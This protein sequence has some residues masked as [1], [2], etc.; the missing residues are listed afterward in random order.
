MDQQG[1]EKI[2]YL[3]TDKPRL[4]RYDKE[5]AKEI[6]IWQLQLT[7]KRQILRLG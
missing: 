5:K 6:I 1:N 4:S 2:A 3:R 7:S